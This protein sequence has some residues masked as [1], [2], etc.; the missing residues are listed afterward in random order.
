MRDTNAR[1]DV[2]SDASH[3]RFK[4]SSLRRLT[5]SKDFENGLPY[6]LRMDRALLTPQLSI[7]KAFYGS[8]CFLSALRAEEN[9]G[10]FSD[11]RLR[12]YKM[13]VGP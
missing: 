10:P 2:N 13:K 3:K 12:Y 5:S 7:R 1:G 11:S 4:S 9:G 6:A 8:A